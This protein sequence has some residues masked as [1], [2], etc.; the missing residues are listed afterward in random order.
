LKYFDNLLTSFYVLAG[1]EG[2]MGE[3]NVGF[4][5][6][7][8]LLLLFEFLGTHGDEFRTNL[9]SKDSVSIIDVET[10]PM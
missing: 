7:F 1:I 9:I 3:M 6:S 10:V 4:T 5:I 2:G 8:P